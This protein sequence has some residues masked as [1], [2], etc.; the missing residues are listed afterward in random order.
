MQLSEEEIEKS[1]ISK[2]VIKEKIEEL[3]KLCNIS[4]DTAFTSYEMF[5]FAK[6]YAS[7]VK[8]ILQDLLK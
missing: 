8:N 6:M 3:E 7:K 2:E 4:G 1:Y 5:V